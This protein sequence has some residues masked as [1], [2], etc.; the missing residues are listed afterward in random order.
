MI[1]EMVVKPAGPVVGVAVSD[2]LGGRADKESPE[3][4]VSVEGAGPEREGEGAEEG[5]FEVGF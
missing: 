5:G 2:P 4:G 3:E 1:P